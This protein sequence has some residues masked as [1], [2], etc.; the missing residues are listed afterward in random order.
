MTH[1]TFLK[2]CFCIF[3]KYISFFLF[4][5][6]KNGDYYFINHVI[7][8]SSDLFYYLWILLSLPLITIIIFGFLFYYSFRV[9]NIFLFLFIILSLL[10]GEY[11]LYTYL[12]SPLDLTNG[13]Y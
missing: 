8:N 7:R 5:M 10:V 3:F 2:I 4:L 9:K 12:A 11:F 13:V 6:I 1:P